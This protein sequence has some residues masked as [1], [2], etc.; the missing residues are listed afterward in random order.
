MR[1]DYQWPLKDQLSVLRASAAALFQAHERGKPNLAERNFCRCSSRAVLWR[2]AVAAAVV[3][4]LSFAQC[5]MP[6]GRG[7]I[8][9]RIVENIHHRRVA[10]A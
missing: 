10:T 5:R 7:A 8:S 6:L 4:N 1:G 2:L 9:A 3:L